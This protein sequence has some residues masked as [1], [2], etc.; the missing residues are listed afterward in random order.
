MGWE[1]GDMY[2][3]QGPH[4]RYAVG[5]CAGLG[6]YG[7]QRMILSTY[8]TDA[9]L[10]ELK[11]AGQ[12]YDVTKLWRRLYDQHS[13]KKEEVEFVNKIEVVVWALEIK[14]YEDLYAAVFEWVEPEPKPWELKSNMMSIV[15]LNVAEGHAFYKTFFREEEVVDTWWPWTHEP[16]DEAAASSSDSDDVSAFPDQPGDTAESVME[17]YLQRVA[18]AQQQMANLLAHNRPGQ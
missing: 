9:S 15:N 10:D 16:E 3:M 6:K 2:W 11:E 4:D 5:R 18:V 17:R 1:P 7:Q 12:F 13:N 8:T 14:V